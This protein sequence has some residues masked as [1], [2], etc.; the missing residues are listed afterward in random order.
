MSRD[1]KYMFNNN[2]ND[3]FKS[4]NR[5]DEMASD[6]EYKSDVPKK[7]NY[8]RMKSC[9]KSRK[10]KRTQVVHDLRFYDLYNTLTPPSTAKSTKATPH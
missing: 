2:L 10:S 5:G 7:H 1:K 4:E 3:S 9:Q 6:D 8:Y